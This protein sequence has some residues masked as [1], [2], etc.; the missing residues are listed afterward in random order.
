MTFREIA[1]QLEADLILS[2][3]ANE[4]FENEMQDL[5]DFSTTGY[6]IFLPSNTA[7]RRLPPS[8]LR[9][10]KETGQ[11][12]AIDSYILDGAHTLEALAAGKVAETRSKVKLHFGNPHN[13][14]FTINGQRV[15]QANQK[16]PSG[17]IVHV[18]D[19]LLYPSADKDIIDTLKSCGRLDGFVTLAEGTGFAQI[20]KKG[21]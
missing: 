19:G 5:M 3:V 1:H 11:G 7:V 18:I 2:E 6:T 16:A 8:L 17:G 4:K 12:L 14:T 15:V 13:E 20:L 10:W 9:R 21:N